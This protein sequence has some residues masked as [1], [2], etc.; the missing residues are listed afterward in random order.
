MLK[1]LYMGCLKIVFCENSSS[2]HQGSVSRSQSMA[3]VKYILAERR[4]GVKSGI[5]WRQDT[6]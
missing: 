6:S 5:G 3:D 1:T 4:K 2:F